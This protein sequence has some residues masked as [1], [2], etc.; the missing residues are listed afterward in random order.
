[1]ISPTDYIYNKNSLAGIAYR[2]QNMH[3]HL[4]SWVIIKYNQF[5]FN[6]INIRYYALSCIDVTVRWEDS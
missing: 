5:F 4:K 1:M 3:S 6:K 2:L